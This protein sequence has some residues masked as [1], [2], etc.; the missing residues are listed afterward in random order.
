MK[1]SPTDRRSKRLWYL[2]LGLPPLAVL[3]PQLYASGG[4]ELA[5]IPFFYWYQLAWTVL[6]GAVVGVVYF[7]TR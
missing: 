1:R 4:P 6:T 7:A 2:L 5:G 3:F